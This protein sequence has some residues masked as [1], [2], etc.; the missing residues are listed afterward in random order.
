MDWKAQITT[1][2]TKG[3]DVSFISL[4]NMVHALASLRMNPSYAFFKAWER[5]AVSSEM[6]LLQKFD[7]Q[8][9]SN[10]LWAFAH[11]HFL[12][13]RN[14]LMGIFDAFVRNAEYTKPQELSDFI[15]S[16]SQLNRS[17]KNVILE[18]GFT[19]KVVH[20]WTRAFSKKCR[21]MD[22][23]QLSISLWAIAELIRQVKLQKNKND[24]ELDTT[25]DLLVHWWSSSG[26]ALI[27]KHWKESFCALAESE[28]PLFS[29]QALANSVWACSQ[30]EIEMETRV[31]SNFVR[32][33][34]NSSSRARPLEL[35]GI[36]RSIAVLGIHPGQ[37]F[38]A[39][40]TR[41]LHAKR[42]EFNFN[43]ALNCLASFA[44]HPSLNV[45]QVPKELFDLV[46]TRFFEVISSSS[47]TFI[48]DRELSELIWAHGT[49]NRRPSEALTA[50]FFTAFSESRETFAF[51]HNIMVFWATSHLFE[52]VPDAFIARFEREI[53]RSISRNQTNSSRFENHAVSSC[54]NSSSAKDGRRLTNVL[55]SYARVNR[56]PNKNVFKLW[57]FEMHEYLKHNECVELCANLLRIVIGMDA[58]QLNMELLHTIEGIL[59]RNCEQL[60]TQTAVRVWWTLGR[61]HPLLQ[62]SSVAVE[63]HICARPQNLNVNEFAIVLSGYAMRNQAPSTEFIHIWCTECVSKVAEANAK[64]IDRILISS[65]KLHLTLPYPFLTQCRYRF[66]QLLTHYS[67]KRVLMLSTILGRLRKSVKS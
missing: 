18:V 40:W 53:M 13:S 42:H 1:E 38:L 46:E 20:Y 67:D 36:L 27:S 10:C 33:F 14:T 5:A 15:W 25:H 22:S 9:A 44:L 50:C 58:I 2:S 41:A 8:A 61:F 57:E 6:R 56:V 39:N 49:L 30:L 28:S 26:K 29:S 12:P 37:Q 21:V 64:A 32:M 17:R 19:T 63:K 34:I 65:D 66:D 54:A 55:W 16:L 62:S 59:T 60:S 48:T 3:F 7:S 47:P 45:S 11:L 31:W 24:H 23:Q 51:E 52:S 43:C 35:C 4:S